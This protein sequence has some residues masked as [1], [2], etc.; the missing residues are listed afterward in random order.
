MREKKK[1]IKNEQNIVRYE[2]KEETRRN[3][4]DRIEDGRFDRS[5]DSYPF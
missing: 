1:K 5:Y 3:D 4:V 2:S